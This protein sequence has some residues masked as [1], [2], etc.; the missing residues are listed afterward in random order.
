MSQINPMVLFAAAALV[1]CQT[2]DP[3]GSGFAVSTT[4][5]NSSTTDAAP[6]PADSSTST[7]SSGGSGGAS[8]SGSASSSSSSTTGT[9]TGSTSTGG[10]GYCGDGIVDPPTEECEDGNDSVNDGCYACLKARKVF[11]TSEAFKPHFGG[12]EG[13][14]SLCRQLANKGGLAR[15]QTFKAWLSDSK[16]DAVDRI[17]LGPGIYVRVDEEVVVDGGDQF[18]SG[19]LNVPIEIDEYGSKVVASAWTGTRPDGTAV[20]GA[21]HC[22]D[23][24]SDAHLEQ[25]YYGIGILSDSR[26]TFDDEPKTNPTSCIFDNRLYCIEGE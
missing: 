11:I 25:G 5:V 4:T 13:A 3:I 19:T 23:W 9:A 17:Y 18:L 6:E 16:T 10:P 12:L 20:P 8:A 2:D 15:W 14:D 1:A 26:W 7:G 24:H 21:A 22:S